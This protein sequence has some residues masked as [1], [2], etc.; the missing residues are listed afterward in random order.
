M[1][2]KALFKYLCPG[3]IGGGG[4]YNARLGMI[5]RVPRHTLLA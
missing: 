5:R 1:A 2:A 4:G 3:E